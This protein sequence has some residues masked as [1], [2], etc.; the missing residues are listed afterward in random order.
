MNPGGRNIVSKYIGGGLHYTGLIPG[1]DED[2]TAFGV[3]SALTGTQYTDNVEGARRAETAIELTHRIP[4]MP[5]EALQP[6]LQYIVRPGFNSDVSH[7]MIVGAR[8]DV[9]F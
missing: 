4:L 1:R 9:V 2:V 5:G 3:A 7:A 8:L 6:D